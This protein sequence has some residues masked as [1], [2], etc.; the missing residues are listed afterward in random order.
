MGPVRDVSRS[1][2]KTAR[3]DQIREINQKD[4][5]EALNVIKPST[6]PQLMKKVRQFAEEA[7]QCS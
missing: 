7:G 2:L 6:N 1:Q 5:F 4:F 3:E